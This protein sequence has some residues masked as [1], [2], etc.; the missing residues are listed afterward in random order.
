M[1]STRRSFL[2][3][4]AAAI[5]LVAGCTTFSSAPE[6]DDPPPAGA[7]DQPDR[8]RHVFGASG[9]WS[10]FGANAAN[11]RQVADGEAPVDGVTEQWRAPFPELSHAEPIVADG[12]VYVA[13]REELRALDANSGDEL[14]T[15]AGVSAPPLVL[16]GVVYAATGDAIRALDAESGDE[17]WERTLETA[18]QV[19]A[20]STYAGDQ[21]VCGAG[22][23]VVSLAPDSGE[24][25][26]T[27]DVFGQVLDHPAFLSGHWSV[28][29]TEAGRVYLLNPDG[30]GAWQWQLPATPMAPPVVDAES[31]YVNCRDGGTYALRDGDDAEMAQRWRADT[32]WAPGGVGFAD[33][34]AFVANG[35]HLEAID[36]ESGSRAWR[37]PT[38]DWTQTAPTFARDTVFVGGD[39]LYAFD[40]T[41]GGDPSG[42][43]ALRFEHSFAGRVGP[44]PVLDDGTLYVAAE[45]EDGEVALVALA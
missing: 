3:S 42:G 30:V 20:P 9:E 25:R 10:S 45:V 44:G 13:T 40:P 38:G 2:A 29:A 11:N 23:R 34:L 33:G 16:D 28:V 17:V 12:T 22:E 18:G 14:W 5:P 41:P 19:T 43:P 8:D 7:D 35:S 21:L 39:A 32:G 6:P 27:Q 31:V 4:T 1:P 15:A 26:W 24:V 37:E 36:T